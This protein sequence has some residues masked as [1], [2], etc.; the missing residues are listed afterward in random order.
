MKSERI[1]LRFSKKDEDIISW[2]LMLR[3]NQIEQSFAVKAL[4]KAFFLQETINGGSIKI[5]HN[6][7]MEPTSIAINEIDLNDDIIKMKTKGIKLASFTKDIIRL[8]INISDIDKAPQISELQQIHTKYKLKYLNNIVYEQ[9]QE[10]KVNIESLPKFKKN[11][12][13]NIKNENNMIAEESNSNDKDINSNYE[14]LIKEKNNMDMNFQSSS[15][16]TF[17]DEESNNLQEV[18]KIENDKK[19]KSKKRNPLLAQI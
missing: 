10:I 13:N 3:E 2:F 7:K 9:S 4:L 1:G 11:I 17:F 12:I 18:S 5:R 6:V 16:I 14:N 15:K 19:V 8:Y